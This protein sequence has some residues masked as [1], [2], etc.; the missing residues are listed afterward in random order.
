MKNTKVET[1][2]HLTKINQTPH[3]KKL[4]LQLVSAE[5]TAVTLMLPFNEELIGDPINRLIHSGALT[6]LVDTASGVAIFQAQKNY[7]AMAT[8]DLRIDHIRKAEPDADIYARADCFR[9]T[10]TIA[11][12]R[13]T[14]YTSNIEEPV[15]TSIAS[16]MRSNKEF[17]VD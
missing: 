4:N 2:P 12:V 1:N 6:T 15:A 11:F 3:G 7:R 5:E 10:H 9:L 8:L 13:A 14:V 17:P 16:F